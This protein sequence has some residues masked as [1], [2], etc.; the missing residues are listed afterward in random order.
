M[1]NLFLLGPAERKKG[2]KGEKK[3]K[4]KRTGS[5]VKSA[6]VHRDSLTGNAERGSGLWLLLLDGQVLTKQEKEERER[7]LCKALREERQL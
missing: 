6:T 2:R 3:E 1:P 5:I 4:K 7:A